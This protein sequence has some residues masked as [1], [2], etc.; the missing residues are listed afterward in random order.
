[1]PQDL[2][3]V[4]TRVLESDVAALSDYGGLNDAGKVLAGIDGYYVDQCQSRDG[5]ASQLVRQLSD[6][7]PA[8]SRVTREL[9]HYKG[10]EARWHDWQETVRICQ[11]LAD[12]IQEAE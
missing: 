1:M 12:R 6:P 8:D 11:E 5:V 10:L 2:T 4:L 3:P 7:R 9:A